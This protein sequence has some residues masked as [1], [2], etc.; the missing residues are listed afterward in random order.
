VE[1]EGKDKGHG[2]DDGQAASTAAPLRRWEDWERSR[3]K[4]MRRDEKRRRDLARNFPGGYIE[5][6]DHLH[7]RHDNEMH[8]SYY[9]NT[10]DTLSIVSS[11]AEDDQ[12]GTQIGAYNENHSAFPPPPAT[13]LAPQSEVLQ[14]A[15]TVGM[16]ELEAMLDQGFEVASPTPSPMEPSS[17]RQSH[18]LSSNQHNITRYQLSERLPLQPQHSQ[19]EPIDSLGPL[20]LR[21][22]DS[23]PPRSRAI[24]PI[25]PTTSSHGISSALG[26]EWKTH[27]KKRSG[28]GADDE[29]WG[30]LGPLGGSPR[31]PP[32]RRI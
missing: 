25:S 20:S 3:L 14:H 32:S 24:S 5:G 27:A 28:G 13:L 8:A 29:D 4:K 10:S 9:E 12:W 21:P 17:R 30:P 2:G 16:D 1:G 31:L 15:Q 11:A 6:G 23:T 18:H 19:S 7:P 26:S 22:K